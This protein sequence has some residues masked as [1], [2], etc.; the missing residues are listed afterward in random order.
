VAIDDLV[1]HEWPPE[2]AAALDIWRQGQLLAV[3]RG[4]WLAPAGV[5]DPVTGD[6]APETPGG[7]RARSDAFG[8]TGYMA[9]VSQT[10]D[11]AVAGP[12]KRHPSYRRV[13]SATSL[14]SLETIKQIK[15][16]AVVEYVFLSKPPEGDAQWAVDLRAAVP[17]SKAVLAAT[18][19]IDGFANEED[20]LV[21]GARIADKFERP[22]IHDALAGPVIGSIRQLL[23]RAK[24]TQRWCDEIEQLRLEIM[25]GTRLQPKR[26]RLFV[27]TDV[28]LSPDEQKPL[29]DEWKSHSKALMKAGIEQAPIAF[30][31]IDRCS[32]KDYREQIPISVPTLNRGRFA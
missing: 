5:D 12:G 22:A 28:P 29:R 24:K 21:L 27:Y 3:D 14:R 8:D 32:L 23:S 20:E 10:C 30:R 2:I 25:E 7:V 9:V 17:V 1:P 26:V 6:A 18:T 11:I 13:R 19:P 16:G 31:T 4:V 15:S